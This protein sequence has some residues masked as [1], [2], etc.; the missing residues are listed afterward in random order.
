M[1]SSYSSNA[2]TSIIYKI[3]FLHLCIKL[4]SNVWNSHAQLKRKSICH[5]SFTYPW[6]LYVFHLVIDF[7]TTESKSLL[8]KITVENVAKSLGVIIHK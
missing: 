8:N 3:R 6:L 4:E 2:S 7:S 5:I 1:Y